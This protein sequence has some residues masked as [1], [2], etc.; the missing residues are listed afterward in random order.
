MI[1]IEVRARCDPAV[2]QLY[3]ISTGILSDSDD[4]IAVNG[5]L[6]SGGTPG[7]VPTGKQR[8]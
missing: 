3:V 8:V 2:F 7:R 6:E 5:P 1:Y 4:F